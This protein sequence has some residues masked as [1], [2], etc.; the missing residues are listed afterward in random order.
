MTENII[1][2]LIKNRQKKK[3]KF[4]EKGKAFIFEL[5]FSYSDKM[6]TMSHTFVVETRFPLT[7]KDTILDLITCL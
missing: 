4:F 6:K 7:Y 1:H 2:Y 5:I 3:L